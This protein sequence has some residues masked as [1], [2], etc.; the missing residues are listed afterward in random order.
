MQR[1]YAIQRTYAIQRACSYLHDEVAVP[2][3]LIVLRLD[4]EIREGAMRTGREE[5]RVEEARI[6]EASVEEA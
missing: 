4:E 6:E 2:A 5:G 3:V 1:I